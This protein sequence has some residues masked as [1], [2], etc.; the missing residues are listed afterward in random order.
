MAGRQEEGS[1]ASILDNVKKGLQSAPATPQQLGAQDQVTA[2]S[3][4]TG[5]KAVGS[6]TTPQAS[7]QGVALAA[8]QTQQQQRQLQRQQQDTAAQLGQAE[9]VQ[10]QAM[11][12][13]TQEMSQRQV[14]AKEEAYQ[15]LD[16]MLTDISRKWDQLRLDKNKSQVEQA[17]FLMRLNSEK[18]TTRLEIEGRKNRLTE[19]VAFQEALQRAIFAEERQLFESNLQFKSLLNAEKREFDAQLAEMD[20]YQAL[21]IADI[22]TQSKNEQAKWSAIGKIVTGATQLGSKMDFSSSPSTNAVEGT[23]I[24]LQSA[25]T[26]M[27]P[28]APFSATAPQEEW[29]LDT[30]TYSG[31]WRP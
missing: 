31:P 7:Q 20:L 6:G 23:G 12:L 5:G 28:Q 16:T 26:P 30:S 1:V 17:G 10:Q 21:E 19:K 9:K 27:G 14:Q 11:Q 29:G 8:Q 25:Q 13:K 4:A 18:Y 22:E 3:R 15:K 24:P 2:L